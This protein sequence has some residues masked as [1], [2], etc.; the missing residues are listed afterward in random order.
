MHEELAGRCEKV[1][2]ALQRHRFFSIFAYPVDT[3]MLNIPDYPEVV[4]NPMDLGTVAD[5]MRT[6]E[7]KPKDF[8]FDCRQGGDRG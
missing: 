3:V 6:K 4:K 8:E 5:K 2:F 7:Y 1:L